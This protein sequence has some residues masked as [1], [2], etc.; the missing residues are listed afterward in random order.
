[1]R[2]KRRCYL[3][4][5]ELK[6]TLV[7]ATVAALLIF[8]G[9]SSNSGA[10]SQ[11]PGGMP[12][13]KL[14][15]RTTATGVHILANRLTDNCLDQLFAQF[16]H[17][18]LMTSTGGLG[19]PLQRNLPL[20]VQAIGADWLTAHTG[21]KVADVRWVDAAGRHDEMRPVD[22]WVALAGTLIGM[23]LTGGPAASPPPLINSTLTAYSA[24]GQTIDSLTVGPQG[25]PHLP[26][27]PCPQ[28]G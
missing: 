23:G 9:C 5:Q 26:I 22:G 14:F 18:G 17:A 24:S 16:Q 1:M 8:S 19:P 25:R 27:T 3:R 7:P 21:S 6:A 20:Q 4:I 2:R 13:Q 12:G 10:L 28:P 15:E 11:H